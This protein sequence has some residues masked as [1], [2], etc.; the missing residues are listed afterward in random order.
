MKTNKSIGFFL[1]GYIIKKKT[2]F[3]FYFWI[4]YEL[5]RDRYVKL[6]DKIKFR[7]KNCYNNYY[8]PKLDFII[9]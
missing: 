2:N 1:K 8:C 9:I 5:F 6:R 3:I 4:N 7:M